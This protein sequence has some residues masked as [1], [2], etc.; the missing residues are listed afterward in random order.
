ME[1]LTQPILSFTSAADTGSCAS[2]AQ[3]LFWEQLSSST[4]DH[5]WGFMKPITLI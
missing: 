2:P 3:G 4:A 5:A 1:T